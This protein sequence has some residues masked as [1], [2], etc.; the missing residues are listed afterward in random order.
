MS[1]AKIIREAIL[2]YCAENGKS[3]MGLSRDL[4]LSVAYLGNASRNQPYLAALALAGVLDF[5]P[6]ILEWAE[7]EKI[8]VRER[9]IASRKKAQP[10][11]E[12]RVF[13]IAWQSWARA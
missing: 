12:V 13:P 5:G 4:G 8:A 9:W 1:E 10:A 3:M 11:V 2:R 6:G 7:A